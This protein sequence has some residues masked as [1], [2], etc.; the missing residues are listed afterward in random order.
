[1]VR[2]LAHTTPRKGECDRTYR[3]LQA[4]ARRTLAALAN[5]EQSD[6]VQ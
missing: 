3:A 4:N 5:D 1:L 2:Q 6:P